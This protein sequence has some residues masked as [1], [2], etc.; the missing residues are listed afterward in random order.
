LGWNRLNTDN[1]EKLIQHCISEC[2]AKTPKTMPKPNMSSPQNSLKSKESNLTTTT[3][4]KSYAQASKIN[5]ED[6]VHIKNMFPTLFPK[7]IVEVNNIIN[8]SSMVKPKIKI[9][10][11][12]PSRK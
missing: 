7:K 11:K 4:R 10:T 6:I 1:N 2:F 3:T 5:V 9:T 12:E 8:K